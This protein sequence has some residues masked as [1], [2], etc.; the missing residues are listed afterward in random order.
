MFPRPNFKIK[1]KQFYYRGKNYPLTEGP[2]AGIPAFSTD[3][4]L[5]HEHIETKIKLMRGM[6]PLRE[7]E[8]DQLIL[9][10]MRSAARHMHLLPATEAHHHR[11][12]MGLLKHS[13]DTAYRALIIAKSKRWDDGLSVQWQIAAILAGLLKDIGLAY[14]NLWVQRSRDGSLWGCEEPLADWLSDSA[15]QSYH[16]SW[17]V[18]RVAKHDQLKQSLPLA[19]AIISPQLQAFLAPVWNGFCI[20]FDV[21]SSSNRNALQKIIKQA[22]WDSVTYSLAASSE[23]IPILGSMPPP[24]FQYLSIIKQLVLSDVLTVNRPD[25]VVFITEDF[26]VM[27]DLFNI[28]KLSKEAVFP[29]QYSHQFR[30]SKRVREAFS[31]MDKLINWQKSCGEEMYY[32]DVSL[33]LELDGESVIVNRKLNRLSRVARNM[34]LVDMPQIQKVKL[35]C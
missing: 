31:E 21:Q 34:F 12:V 5:Q 32:W 6:C 13:L 20:A 33:E 1:K 17:K 18:G 26:G 22:N 4:I 19:E 27:L 2:S 11:E 3:L 7:P 14:E 23:A 15:T 28:S 30:K 35:T 16:V 8:F 9:P 25:S 24:W 10:I 29:A